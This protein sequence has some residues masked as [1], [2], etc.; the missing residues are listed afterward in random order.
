MIVGHKKEG[1]HKQTRTAQ[2]KIESAVLNSKRK[3][4]QNKVCQYTYV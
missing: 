3:V 4:V 2:A 1:K